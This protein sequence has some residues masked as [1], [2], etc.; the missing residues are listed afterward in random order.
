M[1]RTLS[2]EQVDVFT[3][4]RFRGN[5]LAVFADGSGLDDTTMQAIAREMNLSETTFV[6]PAQQDGCVASVRIFTP[7]MELPYAGHPTIGTAWVLAHAGRMPRQQSVVQLEEKVGPVPVRLEGC[8]DNPSSLYLT[9][10]V[11]RFGHIVTDRAACAAAMNV[12]T[13]DLLPDKPIQ[14]VSGPVPFLYFPMKDSAAVDR[15]SIN[16]VAL[17]R[18]M[19]GQDY[20]GAFIFSLTAK[21]RAYSRMLGSE[22]SGVVEDPATGSASGTLGAYL[23]EHGLISGDGVIEV[24][25]EQGTK[26]GRQSFVHVRVQRDGAS[27]PRIEV[28]GSVVPVLRGSLEVD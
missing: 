5:P 4:E 24:L 21:N 19:G 10:P 9:A 17:D 1:T 15:V 27:G 16:A 28:G 26:M 14:I 8:I 25:S 18:V 22:K 23:L 6:L 7:S 13:D 2:F 12:S 20:V 3:N 11:A